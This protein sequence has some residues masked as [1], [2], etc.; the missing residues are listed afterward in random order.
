M[1]E[2]IG[3]IQQNID[4][5]RINFLFYNRARDAMFDMVNELYK[6]NYKDIYIPGYI[7]WSPKEGSG[8][9]DPLNAIQGLKRHYYRM[10]RKLSVDIDSLYQKIKD[11]SILLVVSYFGFRDE[12]IEE[13]IEYAHGKDCVVLEDNAHG[14]YTYFCRGS[15]GADAAFF[16]LHKM[17]PFVQGGGLVIENGEYSKLNNLREPV[18]FDPFSYNYNAIAET[19]IE[20]YLYL[21]SFVDKCDD[22]FVPLKDI[23]DIDNNIPQTFPIVIKRGNRDKIY[24]I[25]NEAGYGV[26]SLYHTIVE[27]LRTDEYRDALWLSKRILNLPIHQDVD[28]SMYKGMIDRLIRACYETNSWGDS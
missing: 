25:M 15:V 2:F 3:K 28:K 5:F 26:V 18:E 9:F 21:Q 10:T 23:D 11:H 16:S 12:K 1:G 20:N 6:K 24:E 19:R 4:N 7:G 27:E 8:I 14:F 17:F 22:Y 13:I